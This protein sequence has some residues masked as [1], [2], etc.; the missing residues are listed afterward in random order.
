MNG[1]RSFLLSSLSNFI[2]Q[3][4]TIL[5]GI[6][7]SVILARGLGVEGRGLYAIVILIPG[8]LTTFLSLGVGSAAVYFIARDE[9]S[10][11]DA[12]NGNIILSMIISVVAM[13]IG[14]F[15]F[16]IGQRAL[17]FE[18]ASLNLLLFAL[19]LVPAT[20]FNT[21]INMLFQGVH[22]FNT[23]NR[24]TIVTSVISVLLNALFVWF[25]A[26][27]V[28]GAVAV[29]VI[30]NTVTIIIGIIGLR[31]YNATWRVWKTPI[32]RIY[33]R[34]VLS[35]G[36]RAHLSLVIAFLNYRVDVLILG[37]ITNNEEVGLYVIA[38]G[39]AERMWILSTTTAQVLFP[40][41]AQLKELSQ[42]QN[43]LTTL[44]A[45]HVLWLGIGMALIAFILSDW[46][47]VLLYG[48][49]FS[50]A[51]LA[52]KWLLP[53]VVLLGMSKILGNSIGARGKPQ[54]NSYQ[55]IVAV[56][57]NIICNIILIPVHGFVGAAM[58]T[59]ISYSVWT[60]I[61]IWYFSY[62]YGI[63]WYDVILPKSTDIVLWRKGLVLLRHSFSANK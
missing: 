10:I 33:F 27:G 52:F 47:F 60:M 24:V 15:I 54:I 34:D 7:T 44:V 41:I 30:A 61:K 37:L 20:L 5:L 25:F 59:T 43:D 26:L 40:R 8:L 39:I 55:S 21:N 3:I 17:L 12:L 48:E 6:I 14:T 63:N 2:R 31:K 49:E 18:G 50:G 53:G 1:V 22:D 51:A 11:R 29:I 42:Q 13:I 32:E 9:Y 28:F 62:T 45:R 58:A 4:L 16:V 35:Y 23:Y 46:V 36:L 57:V 19:L 56:I 38:V